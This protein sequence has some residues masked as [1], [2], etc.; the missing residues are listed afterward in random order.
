MF[1]FE[2]FVKILITIMNPNE[3]GVEFFYISKDKSSILS[4]YAC[5]IDLEGTV[6]FLVLFIQLLVRAI[7]MVVVTYLYLFVRKTNT[8]YYPAK[9]IIIISYC[10]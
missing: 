2:I 3:V 5:G 9:F 8:Q 6:L 7:V 10:K 1:I 4:Y